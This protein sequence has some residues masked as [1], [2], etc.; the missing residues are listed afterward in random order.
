MLSMWL[1]TQSPAWGKRKIHI[2]RKLPRITSRT[3]NTFDSDLL[4]FK[5][6]AL[7]II[8]RSM[9]PGEQG[10]CCF[11]HPEVLPVPAAAPQTECSVSG[12]VNEKLDFTA[13]WSTAAWKLHQSPTGCHIRGEQ[14]FMQLLRAKKLPFAQLSFSSS[15]PCI[16]QEKKPASWAW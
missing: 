2:Y 1:W 12:S 3:H 11:S 8:K 6:F 7:F 4:I 15:H 16:T 9:R 10:L 5:H 13:E 14:G